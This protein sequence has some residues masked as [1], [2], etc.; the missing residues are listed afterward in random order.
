MAKFLIMSGGGDGLGIGLRLKQEGND[1][2]AWIREGQAKSNY[3]GLLRKVKRWDDFLTADTI[4]VFDSSGGG[5]TADRLRARGHFVV[6]GG[7]FADQLELDRAV[8]FEFMQRAG[9]KLPEYQEFSSFDKAKAYVKKRDTRLAFKPSGESAKQFGSYLAYDAEDM[10]EVLDSIGEEHIGRPEFI[11]QDFVEGTEVSSE[12]WFNG[13]TFMRPFNHTIERKHMMDGDLGPSAGCTG[14]IVWVH[15]DPT[16]VMEE[17]ILKMEPI[18]REYNFLGPIDLNTIVNKEGV[19]A[20]E[21]T[22]RF[23]YDAFPSLMELFESPIGP[24]LEAIARG[25]RP[26][27][28]PLK[29]S[30]ASALRLSIP[31]YPTE[32]YKAPEGIP[33]R[34][35]T[36]SDR[37]HLYF[38]DV[39]LNDKLK[40][41]STAACGAIV[42][43]TGTGDSIIEAMEGPTKLAER[44]KIADKQYRTDLVSAFVEHW[45]ELDTYIRKEPALASDTVPGESDVHTDPSRGGPV[46]SVLE[47]SV[48]SAPAS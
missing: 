13:E 22:P 18:L 16:P 10:I 31:P 7:S 21:F 45:C 15:E 1:V 29:N 30:I 35:F 11:L 34:G 39:K 40:L 4:V 26:T 6:T 37:A 43:I 44:A 47:P 36:R 3:D 14:N 48:R 23:G 33:I 25:S 24:T 38:Y 17:G 28:L 32:R 2:A 8:A 20:L 46:G 5:R 12:G 27:R 9:I 41:V 42:T 19:W